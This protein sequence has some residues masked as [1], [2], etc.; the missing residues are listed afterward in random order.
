MHLFPRTVRAARALLLATL[1]ATTLGGPGY[2]R[3]AAPGAAAP[4]AA[5]AG[6]LYA[7]TARGLSA[8]DAGTG[9][10]RWLF[11]P[12]PPSYVSMGGTDG[13]RVFALFRN[14]VVALEAGTGRPLWQRDTQGSEISGFTL[15]DGT[16]YVDGDQGI[17]ALDAATGAVRWQVPVTDGD[18]PVAA[19]AGEMLYVAGYHGQA[20][21]ALDA[22][23]GRQRWTQRVQGQK[24]DRLLGVGGGLVYVR[25]SSAFDTAVFALDGAT[26]EQRWELLLRN[27]PSDAVTT[28]LDGGVAF[29]T[30]QRTPNGPASLAALDGQTGQRRWH[31]DAPGYLGELAVSAGTV[32]LTLPQ[33]AVAAFDAATGQARWQALPGGVQGAW[34]LPAGGTLFVGYGNYE[35]YLRALDAQ[36][37]QIRWSFRPKDQISGELLVGGVIYVASYDH[38]LYAL[39]A[40]T[41]TL[42]WTMYVAQGGASH[43]PVFWGLAAGPLPAEAQPAPAFG[44]YL[45]AGT[46]DGHVYRSVDGGVTWQEADAGIA[47]G[48]MPG[49]TAL[50]VAPDGAT[51]YAGTFADG[52]WVSPDDG[53]SWRPADGSGAAALPPGTGLRTVLVDPRD[54]RHLSVLT[55]DDMIYRSDDGGRSWPTRAHVPGNSYT[56]TLAPGR[57]G[58]LLVGTAGGLWA[59]ADSGRTWTQ[60]L[61]APGEEPVYSVAVDPRHPALA[62]LA[63]STRLYRSADGGGSW[64]QVRAAFGPTIVAVDPSGLAGVLVTGGGSAIARSRDGVSWQRAVVAAPGPLGLVVVAFDPA[65]HARVL[66]ATE[67]G[68]LL[69]ADSGATW[70]QVPRPGA[71]NALVKCLAA[72]PRIPLPSD[73][74]DPPA[75]TAHARYFP[76]TG[77]TLRE[78]FLSF[79]DR[80]GDVA[81]F[82][83]PLTEPFTEYGDTAQ[84]L[85]RVELAYYGGQVHFEPLGGIV[86]LGRTFPRAMPPPIGVTY[87]PDTG[88]TLAAPFL[89]YWR[90]HEGSALIGPPLSEPLREEN[91]DGSGRVYLV[92]YFRNMRLEYHPE[93]AGTPYVVE[94]GLIGRQYLRMRGWL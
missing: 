62:Y 43:M 47:L 52:L 87:F 3:A 57:P 74:V 71:A 26:G 11:A 2:T 10:E 94:P 46:S 70:R 6:T 93:L 13:V 33:A 41:G 48:S 63:T 91:G 58:T 22:R 59:S 72:T 88:H 80:H 81:M 5:T 23:T 75:A 79:W 66:A 31:V 82:G 8:L 78:P 85:E 53:A 15:V 39:D 7:C 1:A 56:L 34:A 30:V 37:G 45:F 35:G 16:L 65:R 90:A 89:A 67:S 19:V 51:V 38:H 68:M 84:Y 40:A 24:V 49:I 44:G 50:A 14:R 76:A 36:T 32:Y 69:S 73:P 55:L 25:R 86:S 29:V 4:G 20:L 77:H 61:G 92:Q 64:T 21:Y 60:P 12:A 9:A 17:T 28:T 18:R 54:G 27:T 83:L 42:R